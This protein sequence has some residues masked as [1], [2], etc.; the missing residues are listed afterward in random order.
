MFLIAVATALAGDFDHALY[1]R[2]LPLVQI[3]PLS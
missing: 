2:L 1:A 3:E